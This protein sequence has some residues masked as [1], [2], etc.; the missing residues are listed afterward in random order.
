MVGL[1]LA[2]VVTTAQRYEWTQTEWKLGS[3]YAS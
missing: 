1:D 2:K 3:G